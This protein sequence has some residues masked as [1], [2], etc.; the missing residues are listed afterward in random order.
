MISTPCPLLIAKQKDAR[1]LKDDYKLGWLF[2][3]ENSY[4]WVVWGSSRNLENALKVAKQ[5]VTE[6]ANGTVVYLS[7]T[8]LEKG[9]VICEPLPELKEMNV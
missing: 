1:F 2:R 5:V 6:K 8:T 3:D 4:L 9:E 7:E